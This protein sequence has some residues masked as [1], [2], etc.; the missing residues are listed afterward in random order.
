MAELATY[1][2]IEPRTINCGATPI[3]R[4]L[5]VIV[6]TDGKVTLAGAAARGEFVTLTDIEANLTGAAASMTGGGKVP[7]VASAA[8]AV[9]DPAFAAA[10]GQFANAG[11]VAIGKWILAASG[12]G[13]LGEVELG[14]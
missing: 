2:G 7:A 3:A 12:A 8:V 13:V 1:V 5:R 10:N 4:G 9:G 6:G 14:M 11:T